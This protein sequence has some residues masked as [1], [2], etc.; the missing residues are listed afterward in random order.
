MPVTQPTLIDNEHAIRFAEYFHRTIGTP[1]PFTQTQAA[2]N[3]NRAWYAPSTIIIQRWPDKHWLAGLVQFA[4]RDPF[5]RTQIGTPKALLRVMGRHDD[6]SPLVDQYEASRT[7]TA[8]R[9]ATITARDGFDM[10]L[11]ALNTTVH[12]DPHTRQDMW[13]KSLPAGPVRD[14]A[15]AVRMRTLGSTNGWYA[16]RDAWS[17]E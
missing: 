6:T 9:T 13:I 14:T 17:G 12:P 16:W 4:A 7:R 2:A 5:W 1:R 11:T 15:A 8:T 10:A 3:W